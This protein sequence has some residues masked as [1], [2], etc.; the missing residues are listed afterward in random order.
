MA[1]NGARSV[2]GAGLRARHTGVGRA[3]GVPPM[4]AKRSSGSC[5][6]RSVRRARSGKS[7]D[8]SRLVCLRMPSPR[9]LPGAFIPNGN[10]RPSVGVTRQP[11]RQTAQHGL[12]WI[13]S[14]VSLGV[15]LAIGGNQLQTSLE[16]LMN[17]RQYRP[18]PPGRRVD[19]YPYHAGRPSIGGRWTLVDALHCGSP[20]VPHRQ[21]SIH[22]A[23]D[24]EV[25]RRRNRGVSRRPRRPPK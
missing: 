23:R 25:L 7:V 13:S 4:D 19:Q 10:I 17:R 3:S 5:A 9:T 16:S 24:Q 8:V 22:A 6:L 15:A 14:V 2:A 18:L 21:L 20:Y 12:H 1:G 11:E